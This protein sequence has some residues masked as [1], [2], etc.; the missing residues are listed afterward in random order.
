MI[1]YDT[2]RDFYRALN[3]QIMPKMARFCIQSANVSSISME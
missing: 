3:N 2:T 1:H